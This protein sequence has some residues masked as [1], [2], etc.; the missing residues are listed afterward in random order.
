MDRCRLPKPQYY[1]SKKKNITIES[2][3][4]N[5]KCKNI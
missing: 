3:K 1:W 5:L 2:S 4:G